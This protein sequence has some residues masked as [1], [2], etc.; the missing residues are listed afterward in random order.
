MRWHRIRTTGVS[1]WCSLCI[2][3][4]L[5]CSFAARTWGITKFPKI[6]V[7]K[8][9]AER[10]KSYTAKKAKP[11][12]KDLEVPVLTKKS[13]SEGSAVSVPEEPSPT[14][15]H[16]EDRGRDLMTVGPSASAGPQEAG[17]SSSGTRDLVVALDS[18]TFVD[19]ALRDPDRTSLSLINAAIRL[20]TTMSNDDGALSTFTMVAAE[21]KKAMKKLLARVQREADRLDAD[22]DDEGTLVGLEDRDGEGELA[23]EE[24]EMEE[25]VASTSGSRAQENADGELRE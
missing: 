16:Y 10:R 22:G 7:S 12:R 8:A 20:Q 5:G 9:S 1:F 4:K 15:S 13:R 3:S 11:P 21:R 18:F 25:P 6:T 24:E 23:G 19:A 2:H 17:P 14:V